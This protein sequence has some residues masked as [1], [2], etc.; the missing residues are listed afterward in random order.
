M[1]APS[2]VVIE[3]INA[4]Y[5]SDQVVA[6]R[7]KSSAEYD[8]SG[9]EWRVVRVVAPRGV[10]VE[11]GKAVW[12]AKSNAKL[13]YQVERLLTEDCDEGRAG[14]WVGRTYHI[15]RTSTEPLVIEMRTV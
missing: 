4:A 10:A 1:S 13:C 2:T 7:Y 6:L 5:E 9:A 15:G 12:E 14:E 11:Q 3:A 8:D